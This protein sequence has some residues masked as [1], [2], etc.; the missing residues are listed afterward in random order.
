[1]WHTATGLFLADGS[2]TP[3][4]FKTAGRVNQPQSFAVDKAWVGAQHPVF[5]KTSVTVL[6]CVCSRLYRAVFPAITD[7]DVFHE[8]NIS[9]A[10]PL[11]IYE[12]VKV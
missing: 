7:R 2:K 12:G 1:M 11:K 5:T 6:R 9:A 3:P 10:S 8:I 4:P